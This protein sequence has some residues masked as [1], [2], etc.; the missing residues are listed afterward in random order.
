[1]IQQ[2]RTSS[3][4]LFTLR[5]A[6]PW[7][8]GLL[9]I[10]ALAAPARG[11]GN[12]WAPFGPGGGS[13]SSLAVDPA[14]PDRI[15]AVAGGV[16]Y[17]SPDASAT[18][19]RLGGVGGIGANLQA[20]ALDPAVPSTL[21]A[22]GARLLRSTD[23][24]ATLED[25]TPAP[26]AGHSGIFITAL[27][28]ARNGAVFAADQDRLL[29]SLD[30]GANWTP[31]S[32]PPSGDILVIL[33]DPNVPAT[34]YYATPS[35]IS[36]S[37]DEGTTWSSQAP[38]SG[39]P[40]LRIALAPSAPGTLY[41]SVLVNSDADTAFFRSDDA[42]ASWWP[43][44]RVAVRLLQRELLVDPRN[45]SVLYAA[46]LDGLF[47]STDAG[48]TWTA[49]FQGLPPFFGGPP[50]VLALALDP[51]APDILYAGLE[52]WGVARSPRGG[53]G[54]RIGVETGLNATFTHLLKFDPRHPD[55]VYLALG[56]E[57]S[58][59][60]RSTDGG[61]T[62][63]PFARNISLSGGLNDLTFDLKSPNVLYAATEDATWKSS[64]G[65]TTW[66]ALFQAAERVAVTGP[67]TLLSGFCGL[68]RSTDGGR[69]WKEVIPCNPDDLS[70][71]IRSLDVDPA[72]P[73]NV[74][75]QFDIHNGGSFSSQT[76]FR[77]RDGGATWK[78]LDPGFVIAPSDFRVLY[79]LDGVML[80]RSGDSGTT[81]VVVNPHVNALAGVVVDGGNPNTVYISTQRGVLVSY[82]GGRTLRLP[83]GA[84]IGFA[85]LL[86]DRQRPGVVFAN[87]NFGFGLF[88]GDFR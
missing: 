32:P 62:W 86:T 48:I 4:R 3:S 78:S 23:G 71:P 39:T 55:T 11:I 76:A 1:M 46:G 53:M 12:R 9:L 72:N 27:A 61:Q 51:S 68:N 63:A 65:G 33:T 45:P 77:S 79:R 64:D 73:L 36:K 35:A 21:Y 84:E 8:G 6:F 82:N 50:S 19:T 16:L 58:R 47:K 28:V 49:S 30:G 83:A 60:F 69:T 44:G 75:A 26:A 31:V 81:W 29:R 85:R 38:F 74:Y 37:T 18:W 54:W 13:V 34:V 40:I 59:S 24:G 56:A 15:Y 42:G 7:L 14:D 66:T 43:L 17:R 22:G 80:L 20:V 5:T 57:G 88:E 10:L 70:Q 41:A 87:A 67:K 52:E 25:V 2:R